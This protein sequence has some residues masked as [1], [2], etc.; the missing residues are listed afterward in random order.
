MQLPTIAFWF[1]V[2]LTIWVVALA[3]GVAFSA[4]ALL[5]GRG[6]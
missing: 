1:S 2:F 4:L 3:F 5:D 6:R